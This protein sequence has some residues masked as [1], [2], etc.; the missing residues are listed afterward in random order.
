LIKVG[1]TDVAGCEF[2]F[3]VLQRSE[4]ELLLGF[5]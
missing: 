3:E 5:K 4:E 2:G 1:L